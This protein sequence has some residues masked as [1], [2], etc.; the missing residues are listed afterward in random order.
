MKANVKAREAGGEK[1]PRGRPR[2]E[3]A[4]AAILSAARE[5]LAELGPSGVTIEGVA[6]RAG[7]GKPT[8]YRWW[9]DRYAV[10]MAAL[11]ESE[12]PP[13]APAHRARSALKSLRVQLRRMAA[14]FATGT[15]RAIAAMLAAAEQETEI[16]RAFRN[17]FVLARR[18]EGR[19]LLREAIAAR[20]ICADIDVDVAL[21][22]IYGPLFFRLL[23]GHA[24]IDERFMERVLDHALHGLR[25]G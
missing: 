1:R 11:M 17:H 23:L 2:S 4:K 7:V 9:P 15:G 22:M 6:A 24:P 21:D 16:S 13:Q 8:I 14:V 5:L 25:Y 18:E 10:V 12:S 20:E 3:R 19:A